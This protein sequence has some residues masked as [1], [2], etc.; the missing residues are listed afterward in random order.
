MLTLSTRS[1]QIVVQAG[2]G[3]Q[4]EAPEAVIEAVREVLEATR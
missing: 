4:Y 1:R 2:H 3:I